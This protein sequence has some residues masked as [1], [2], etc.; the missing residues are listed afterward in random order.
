MTHN[1]S[2]LVAPLGSTLGSTTPAG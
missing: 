1:F 2:V